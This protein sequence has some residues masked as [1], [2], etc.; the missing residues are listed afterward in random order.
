MDRKA[1]PHKEPKTFTEQLEILK[2]RNI[3]I[4][5]DE[6]AIDALRHIN[7][8]RLSGYMLPFKQ[9]KENVYDEGTSLERILRIYDFDHR[10]RNLL[11]SL[12]EHIEISARTSIAYHLAHKHGPLCYENHK[13]FINLDRHQKL[14][15]AIEKSIKDA[16]AGHEPFII[17]HDNRYDGKLPIWSLVEVLS[18]GTLSKLY[19]NL[20]NEDKKIISKTY[21]GIPPLYFESWLRNLSYIRNICAHHSRIYHHPLTHQPKLYADD[22]MYN[23]IF[24]SILIAGVLCPRDRDWVAFRGGLESLV[25]EYEDSI[26]LNHIKF[27]PDWKDVLYG[28]ISKRRQSAAESRKEH[29][30]SS[31]SSPL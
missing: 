23:G 16:R 14:L 17:H 18:F 7:Y 5:N 9:S 6:R 19:A 31:R 26:D 28:T 29:R 2:A 24:A 21:F 11:L 4:K 25:E 1:P 30:K 3:V 12:L 27:P 13:L 10:L 22:K 20:A 15:E 8:Y